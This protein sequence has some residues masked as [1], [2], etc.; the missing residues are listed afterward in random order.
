M[1]AESSFVDT[2]VFLRFITNDI[3]E[4]AGAVERLFKSAVS[5]EIQ[6]ITNELVIAE[7]VWTLE[8]YYKIPKKRIKGDILA[9]LNTPGLTVNNDDIII[10]AIA[11]YEEKNIDFIDAYN[12]SWMLLHDVKEIYSFD[13]RHFRRIADVKCCAP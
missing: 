3:P 12:A 11:W 1:A 5:G 10:Q 13:E 2:N 7:I 9:I 6:L 4:Q 8:T